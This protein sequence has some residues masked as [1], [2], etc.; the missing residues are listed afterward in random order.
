MTEPKKSKKQRS[1]SELLNRSEEIINRSR[2]LFA[3]SS[4][5]SSHLAKL[6]EQSN[7]IIEHSQKIFRIA[8]ELKENRTNVKN[9]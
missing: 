9:I 4:I 3:Q 8:H 6:D 2:E 5:L 1:V 7:V